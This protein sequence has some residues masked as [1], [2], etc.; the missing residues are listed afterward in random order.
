MDSNLV[1][2]I[3]KKKRF[4]VFVLLLGNPEARGLV[5]NPTS[6]LYIEVIRV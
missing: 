3:V 6:L 2:P 1:P 4:E 5:I